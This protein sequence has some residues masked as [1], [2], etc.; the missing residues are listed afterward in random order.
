MANTP[1]ILTRALGFAANKLG[2]TFGQ[3]HVS[4]NQA[5]KIEQPR[6]GGPVFGSS[7]KRNLCILLCK[8]I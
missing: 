6:D 5:S 7:N 4:E 2:G 3:R 8:M 1:T